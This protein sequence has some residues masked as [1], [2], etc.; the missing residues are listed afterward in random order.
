[1][2]PSPLL[3]LLGLG[4]ASNCEYGGGERTLLD[5]ALGKRNVAG[6]EDVAASEP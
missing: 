3:T 5:A 6:E 1:M 2:W 4:F